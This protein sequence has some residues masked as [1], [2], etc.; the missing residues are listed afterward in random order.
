MILISTLQLYAEKQIELTP[1]VLPYDSLN[2]DEV[3]GYG[4]TIIARSGNTIYHSTDDGGSWDIALESA[5]KLNQLYSKDPHTV[6]VIGDS[7]LVYRTMDYG[8]TWIDESVDTDLDLVTMAAKDAIDYLT[9]TSYSIGFHRE[10]IENEYERISNGSNTKISSA[11]YQD[12]IYI[13]GGSYSYKYVETFAGT[14]YYDYYL[15]DFTFDGKSVKRIDSHRFE[16]TDADYIDNYLIDEI[17]YFN[18]PLGLIKSGR[19]EDKG[20][21]GLVFSYYIGNAL[22]LYVNG[23]YLHNNIITHATVQNDSLFVFTE[24]GNLFILNPKDIEDEVVSEKYLEPVKFDIETVNFI[25]NLRTNEYYIASD[26]SMIY[27]AKLVNL[28]SSVEL[29]TDN[30]V[31]ISGRE[32]EFNNSSKQLH[33]TDYMGRKIEANMIRAN[34]YQLE[35]GLNFITYKDKDNR[36][37]TIKVMV[38]K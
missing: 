5:T 21:S 13:F 9:L 30:T 7:G 34:T 16:T 36:L 6:F 31:N 20:H 27:K 29:E 19:L 17:R 15:P 23:L 14:D 24:E 18:S 25:S 3:Y 37:R 38:V 2:I 11:L 33:I 1:I 35:L 26:N 4:A 22:Y 32:L 10:R 8:A 12:S 28:P